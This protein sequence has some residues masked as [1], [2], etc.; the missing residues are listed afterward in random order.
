MPSP[1]LPGETGEFSFEP[2]P[3]S[4]PNLVRDIELQIVLEHGFTYRNRD[5]QPVIDNRPLQ[6]QVL[7]TL[8]TN[9]ATSEDDLSENSVIAQQLYRAVL[10]NAPRVSAS[11][12]LEEK[13][14]RKKLMSRLWGFCKADDD[15]FVQKHI[16]HKKLVLCE[17]R[18][19]R[20][21][22]ELQEPI[23]PMPIGRFLTADEELIVTYFFNP[24]AKKT[25]RA[26]V[27]LNLGNSLVLGR[28]P[29]MRNR[30]AIETANV[31]TQVNS[32]LPSGDVKRAKAL[33]AAERQSDEDAVS[34]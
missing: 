18:V 24:R 19:E 23:T 8:L 3:F 30:L 17:A 9:V 28:L 12:S 20:T 33:S 25:I 5:G 22:V 7:A 16:S 27:N 31:I 29:Q 26:A 11:D 10:P 15:S 6:E 14:A 2:I 32:A 4:D 13:E 21:L 1:L 34:A